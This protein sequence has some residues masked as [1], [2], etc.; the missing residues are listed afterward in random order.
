MASDREDFTLCGPSSHLTN[1]DWANENHQRCVAAC[2]VQGIYIVERDRQ[3]QREGSQALA[4]PWWDSFHFK[5]IRRL[6]DDADFS[7][8]G[9]IYELKPPPQQ[10]DTTTIT[11]VESKSPRYVIAFRGTLTKP[12]SISRDLELDIHI[13]RNGLHRTSRFD[14]AMQAVGSMATSVGAS[15]LWITGHSMGAA[16]AL[17]AGKT[18]AKTGVYVKSFLF[19]P[20][21]VSPPIERIS[22]ERVRSGLRIAGSLVTAGL[23]FSRTLKQAQQPQQQLQERNLSEDPL[24]ALSLWLP[25][26]H[27]N[28]GDHLCSEYIGFFEHRGNMEQL[29]YGAGIVER[30]A[31][32][33]SLGGLL[34]DAM[35]VS[36]AVDVQ[37]PVHVI[38]SAKL[39]VNRTASEDYKEAHGIHQWW[40]DDQDLV[41][42][43]YLFK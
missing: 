33:H 35:G 8:F 28:P 25:D 20:P 5:L 22:N 31:M 43:I 24:K 23:A 2:L 41:S 39:I 21:F 40:R 27:V 11:T 3:L 37:E 14:I 4:S 17:L 19:N 30:M 7:I 26:I 15:N 34:M 6:I 18:L 42:N 12:G 10:E 9:A 38:P 36:N 16:M 13:I 29:G 32:Q 1:L